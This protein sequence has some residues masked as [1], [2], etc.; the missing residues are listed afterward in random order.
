M[1][2]QFVETSFGEIAYLEAGQSGLPPVLFIHGIPTSGWLWR[3]VLGFLQE[4]VH[5][6]APDLMGLGDTRPRS[7]ASFDMDNQAEMLVEFMEA[8]GHR[9]FTV[10]CHD[11]GGAAAQIIATRFTDRVDA[12]VLT[13]CVCYD[14]WPVPVISQFQQLVRIPGFSRLLAGTGL[15][16]M[17]EKYG[18]RA[19]FKRG[20]Y[21]KSKLTNEAID[22]YLR[23]LREGRKRRKAFNKFLLAGH[24]RFTELV[25]DD[26]KKF[27]KP[28]LIVWAADDRYLSPSWGRQLLDDIPG[29]VRMAIVP[30]CGHFWQEERPAE[31]ASYIG[32]FISEQ[33]ASREATKLIAEAG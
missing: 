27:D 24:K 30:F 14:N 7:G 3:H 15:I 2:K 21:D 10:V 25:V 1:Q 28:T 33:V 29:A 22:E 26:L 16:A 32:A 11:Q 23:P 8:L 17:R 6:Y 31:F 12:F 18:R 5:G 13:D 9:T 19:T 4:E 20:V